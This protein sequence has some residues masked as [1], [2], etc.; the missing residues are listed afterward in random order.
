MDGEELEGEKRRG[1]GIRGRHS[2]T[3]CPNVSES[4]HDGVGYRDK[5]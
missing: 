3:G 2:L 4:E 1:I 5:Q